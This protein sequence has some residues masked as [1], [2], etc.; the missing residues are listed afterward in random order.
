MQKNKV[1]EKLFCSPQ[2]FPFM[3]DIKC[4]GDDIDLSDW[5]IPYSSDNNPSSQQLPLTLQ[6]LLWVHLF[7][8]P[9]IDS[10]S[11]S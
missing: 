4:S 2:T 10:Y 5:F 8:V 7:F 11:K 6:H 1:K 9:R 3:P